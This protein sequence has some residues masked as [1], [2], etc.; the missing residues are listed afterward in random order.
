M[1]FGM[2]NSDFYTINQDPYE[3]QNTL[4]L[5]GEFYQQNRPDNVQTGYDFSGKCCGKI[6]FL[7]ILSDISQALFDNDLTDF[8]SSD[9]LQSNGSPSIMH[10]TDSSHSNL[11]ASHVPFGQLLTGPVSSNLGQT[12]ASAW[13]QQ[14]S[15]PALSSYRNQDHSHISRGGFRKNHPTFSSLLPHIFALASTLAF[16]MPTVNI[17][18]D[19][20]DDEDTAQD[21]APG[22]IITSLIGV[23]RLAI[24]VVLDAFTQSQQNIYTQDTSRLNKSLFT[25]SEVNYWTVSG[26]ADQYMSQILKWFLLDFYQF[27]RTVRRAARELVCIGYGFSA[28]ASISDNKDRYRD[29]VHQESYLHYFSGQVS[30]MY[31]VRYAYAKV[32]TGASIITIW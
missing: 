11:S 13:P 4:Q 17:L 1:E 26:V 27:R 29:V 25:L 32:F 12:S 19:I 2:D 28:T 16:F 8:M 10:T 15:T 31:S 5:Q 23:G 18:Q 3:L 24:R 21:D 6:W 7:I 20:D 14:L 30:I 22:G 9:S